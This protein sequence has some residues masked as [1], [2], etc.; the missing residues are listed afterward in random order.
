MDT[1]CVCDIL[2]DGSPFRFW[3]CET[4]FT[5][6]YHVAQNHPLASDDNPGT[7][8][9]PLRTIGRACSLVQPGQRVVIHDGVYRE[10]VRPQRGGNSP[11]EMIS[12]EAAPGEHAVVTGAE[13]WHA[14]WKPSEGWL[15]NAY[16]LPPHPL[17]A[18]ARVWEGRLPEASLGPNS[19]FSTLNLPLS[20]NTY[21]SCLQLEHLPKDEGAER[22]LLRLESMNPQAAE[23][24]VGQG[25]AADIYLQRRG[26]IF[27][28]GRPLRQVRNYWQLWRE[29]G[30]FWV[31]ADGL[32][33][34]LRLDDDGDPRQHSLE[35]TAREQVFAPRQRYLGYIRIKGLCFERVGNGF[36][37]PQCAAVSTYCGHHWIIEDNTI[38]WINAIGLDIGH[39]DWNRV[40]NEAASG[41]HI[42]RRNA[43]S[44]CGFNG[45]CGIGAGQDRKLEGVLV[46]DNAFE[47]C[48]WHAA[49]AILETASIKLHHVRNSLIC[50]NSVRHQPNGL[51][52]I[53]IDYE[54]VN[55]RVCH[56]L[57]R[58]CQVQYGGIFFEASHAPN[59]IVGNLIC[60][61][62][63]PQGKGLG[64][65]RIYVL[66]SDPILVKGNVVLR[67]AGP[68]IRLH[69]SSPGRV[70]EGRGPT[71]YHQHVTDNVISHCRVAVHL[72]RSQAHCEGNTYGSFVEPAPFRIDEPQEYLDLAAWQEFHRWDMER[73]QAEIE[74]DIDVEAHAILVRVRGDHGME[75]IAYPLDGYG[76]E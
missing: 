32:T 29:A 26:L 33:V 47:H 64:G 14:D 73:M 38:C 18:D 60:D 34:H 42:V 10:C 2:P 51:G 59:E 7:A 15:V 28:D 3:D 62:S 70:T 68:A 39:G 76:P 44:H 36:P 65:A 48:V 20:I 61:I 12:F 17:D 8:E 41:W 1:R 23:Q 22:E 16:W 66:N 24:S 5:R 55:T 30:T 25:S 11:S 56:N 75:T 71:G 53:W 67:C 50:R 4:R 21:G 19:P 69:I 43:F 72:A 27:V 6:T 63:R 74:S 49:D 40:N 46:S 35:Y 57:V 58:N 52:A 37:M 13:Q 31:E 9:K 45:L 54:N